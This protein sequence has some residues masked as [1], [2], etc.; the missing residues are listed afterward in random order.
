MATACGLTPGFDSRLRKDSSL[1]YSTH[2]P[3]QRVPGRQGRKT[4]QSLPSSAEVKN[5]GAKLP[6]AP[7]IFMAKVFN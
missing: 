7:Y 6:L 4:D 3:I 5:G 2:P 1:I